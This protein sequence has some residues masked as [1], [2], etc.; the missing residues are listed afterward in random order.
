M[1]QDIPYP[2]IAAVS[3]HLGPLAIARLVRLADRIADKRNRKR[4][5]KAE[6]ARAH[7]GLYEYL[8][9]H[10]NERPVNI[11]GKPLSLMTRR[12]GGRSM[13][14]P[15]CSL[16]EGSKVILE[17][18]DESKR[19]IYDG[20]EKVENVK[21]RRMLGGVI[22]DYDV[23]AAARI[24]V[25]I[26]AAR[27]RGDMTTY[28][29]LLATQD[30]LEWEILLETAEHL[31]SPYSVSDFP[32]LTSRLHL[33]IA[34]EEAAQ[35]NYLLEPT[36]RCNGLAISTSVVHATPAGEFRVILGKRSALTGAHADLFHVIPAC[37]FQPELG[38]RHDEWDIFHSFLKEYGEELY[39]EELDRKRRDARY[40]YKEWKGV[41]A[42]LEA[43]DQGRCSFAITGLVINLLNLR[44]EVCALLLV[45][46]PDWWSDVRPPFKTGWEYVEVEKMIDRAG[47]CCTDISLRNAEPE[48]LEAFG[49][50]PRDWVPPGL[51][52]FWLGIDYAR[53]HYGIEAL[54][55]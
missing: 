25:S 11:N 38:K 54:K 19:R 13:K 40:F 53:R 23:F 24:E 18:L 29:S 36:T 30:A 22:N 12:L 27:I 42:L 41:A 15:V 51:A 44:P 5:I 46:D 4:V 28:G 14:I 43:M 47:K 31:S 45:H 1:T 35:K 2:E 8:D 37:I 3:A 6:A 34:A 39:S 48:Y 33:R 52:C 10:L 17:S 26:E 50:T 21:I 20:W 55:A 49:A 16:F 9:Y 32:G 7:E